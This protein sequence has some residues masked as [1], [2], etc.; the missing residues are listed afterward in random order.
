MCP[1]HFTEPF[2]P[3]KVSDMAKALEIS[4]PYLCSHFKEI[5]GITLSHYILTEKVNEAKRLLLFTDK[6]LSDISMHLAFS[7]QSHFQTVFKKITGK[8]PL[9]YRLSE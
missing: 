8:T 5:T 4:R 1:L 9:G 6:S 3:I 2:T 7:S